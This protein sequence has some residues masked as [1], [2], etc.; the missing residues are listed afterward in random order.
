MTK[1]VFIL[2]CLLCLTIAHKKEKDQTYQIYQPFA[3]VP[4]P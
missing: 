4:K 2:C 3:D 1:T